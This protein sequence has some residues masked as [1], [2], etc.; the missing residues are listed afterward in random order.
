MRHRVIA[1]LPN[2]PAPADNRRVYTIQRHPVMDAYEWRLVNDQ[3]ITGTA[4]ATKWSATND[5]IAPDTNQRRPMEPRTRV[6]A[7]RPDRRTN[8]SS[9]PPHLRR[10]QPPRPRRPPTPMPVH[11]LCTP[12]ASHRDSHLMGVECAGAQDY[13]TQ[14][15]RWWQPRMR[16]AMAPAAAAQHVFG[17]SAPL[18]APSFRRTM[19]GTRI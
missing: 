8:L 13:W 19:E 18:P 12:Q 17:P 10:A 2:D 14:L 16:D 11:I 6:R 1:A 3:L 15:L 9:V 4:I 7:A 5:A